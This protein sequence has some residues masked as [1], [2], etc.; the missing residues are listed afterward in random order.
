MLSSHNRHD[1][2]D[3]Q[4]RRRERIARLNGQTSLFPEAP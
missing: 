4:R 2:A 1:A 3:R